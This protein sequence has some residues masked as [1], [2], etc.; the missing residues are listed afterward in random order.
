MNLNTEFIPFARPSIGIA[1]EEAVLRVLRSGWLTTGN[2][3]HL[4]EQEFGSFV[5]TRN[6][7]AVNSATAGLHLAL[8]AANVRPGDRVA[9]SPYT[10]ASTAEVVRYVGADPLFVDIEDESCN[11][12]PNELEVAAEKDS[13]IRAVMPVHIAGDPCRMDRILDLADRY[14]LITVE[15]AA[16]AFPVRVNTGTPPRFAGTAGSIGVYSFYAT[17][18][19][20]TGEGGMVVT[21]DE[22]FA[23]RMKIMRLH[24][25]DRDVWNRYTARGASWE[26]AVVAPGYKYNLTDLAAAIGRVQLSQAEAFLA[27]R[28]AIARAYDEAFRLRDYL[29]L[30][31]SGGPRYEHHAWHLYMLRVR[32]ERLTIDRNQ[33]IERLSAEGIGTSVHFIPLHLMPYYRD[34]YGYRPEDFPRSLSRFSTTISLPIY[35]GLTDDQVDRIMQAVL[36]IGDSCHKVS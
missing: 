1:E 24:G 36:R 17:K 32:P 27:R 20:T 33:F 15:D 4:F 21:D 30:P 3:A 31:P 9:M 25:I 10:F 23:R 11:I 14:N 16:H 34:R 28:V 5:G 22:G 12:D 35:P 19:I 2:E 13:T 29:E 18:T 6:A 26:Y 7:L 8:E